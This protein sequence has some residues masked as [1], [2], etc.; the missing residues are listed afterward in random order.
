MAETISKPS[1]FVQAPLFGAET[2]T[3]EKL[4][5]T[6]T[7]QKALISEGNLPSNPEKLGL[8]D[9]T[10]EELVGAY[11]RLSPQEQRFH[12]DQ[13]G[14]PVVGFTRKTGKGFLRFSAPLSEINSERDR[15]EELKKNG[16]QAEKAKPAPHS[17]NEK[18]KLKRDQ[19]RRQFYAS[20]FRRQR[21]FGEREV[22]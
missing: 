6:S 18:A 12:E 11:D 21:E 19:K 13:N 20:H 1:D 10:D 22:Y 7:A 2:S 14:D 17:K 4:Q 9:L 3:R 15:R 8:R 5:G 16:A